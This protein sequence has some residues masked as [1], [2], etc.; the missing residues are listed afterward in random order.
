MKTINYKTVSKTDNTNSNKITKD[1]VVVP[2]KILEEILNDSPEKIPKNGNF[3]D[4]SLK[5]LS[6]SLAQNY[7]NMIN[8]IIDLFSNKELIIEDEHFG[9][10]NRYK[11]IMSGFIKIFTKKNRLIYS[12]LLILFISFLLYFIDISSK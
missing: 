3:F 9:V 10:V 2:S 4:I 1:F 12:G 6:I 11:Y 7:K 5:N 8:E